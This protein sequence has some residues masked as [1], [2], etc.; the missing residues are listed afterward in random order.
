MS[1][2]SIIDRRALF[3]S[4]AAAALL[5]ATGLSAGPAPS[6]GGRLRMALSGGSREDR[7]DA[8][9]SNGLFMKVAM[10]GTVFDTLTEIA[11]DGTLRGELALSWQSDV[12]ARIWELHL[13]PDVL[14]HDGSRFGASDVARTFALHKTQLLSDVSAIDI[15]SAEKLR[16]TL[17]KADPD[18]PYRLSDP[19]LVIYPA[20]N[21]EA[22][23]EEGIGTGLYRTYRFDPGRQFI[24]E[25]VA[26]HYKDG[27]AG[28]FDSVELVSLSSDAVRAE[29]LREHYVDAADLSHTAD[30]GELDN[31]RALPKG[32]FM[33][34][35]VDHCVA[36]PSQIG[37]RWPMDNLR[38]AERWWKA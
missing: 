5:T 27:S 25:R 34:T 22:A 7:F 32:D 4:G 24:G 8:L 33:T 35:A 13:R 16:V 37:T 15:L 29:A 19:Q 36:L 2:H 10:A 31:I 38:A 26:S 14:F 21:M 11:S 3:A 9:Q 6:R 1:R 12:D 23:M 17:L 28:W 20:G 18:F 30:L